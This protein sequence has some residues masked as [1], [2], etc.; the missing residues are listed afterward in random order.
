MALTPV[1]P[2][3]DEYELWMRIWADILKGGDPNMIRVF[4]R[5]LPNIVVEV[6]G[7]GD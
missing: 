5:Y 4:A 7:G 6:L 3:D 1:I 2:E